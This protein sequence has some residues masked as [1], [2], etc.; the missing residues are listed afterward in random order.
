[1][2]D[3]VCVCVCVQVLRLETRVK[4]KETVDSEGGEAGE[5]EE[6]DP[7]RRTFWTKRA[8]LD[9]RHLFLFVL[10]ICLGL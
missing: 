4:A 9:V 1:M 5:E 8:I 7:R 3:C 2:I 6:A 10:H